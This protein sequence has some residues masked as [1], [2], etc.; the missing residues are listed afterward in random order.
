[1]GTDAYVPIICGNRMRGYAE[2][3]CRMVEEPLLIPLLLQLCTNLVI[4]RVV[5]VLNILRF[6]PPIDGVQLCLGASEKKILT[7]VRASPP[8]S[9]EAT[10]LHPLCCECET[11]CIRTI[12]DVYSVTFF[13]LLLLSTDLLCSLPIPRCVLTNLLSGN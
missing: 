13:F 8:P 3:R 7:D 5:T 10:V 11:Q 9:A 6:L 1:M 2:G 4:F 12:D